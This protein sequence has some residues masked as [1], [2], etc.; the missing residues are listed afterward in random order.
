M[1]AGKN[2]NSVTVK[3]YSVGFLRKIKQ[4]IA[5]Y[6][7]RK[8]SQGVSCRQFLNWN[9]VKQVQILFYRANQA[10][11]DTM[12]KF[13]KFLLDEGKSVDVLIFVDAKK[14]DPSLQ[15][16]KGIKYYCRKQVNW[17]GKPA[18]DVY[19]DF[20]SQTSD[21]LIVVDFENRFHFQ[22]IATLSKAKTIV[23]PFHNDNLWATLLLKIKG[24]DVNEFLQQVI[25]YLGFINKK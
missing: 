17:F 24:N 2:L 25:H 8:A 10:Q 12:S 6:S 1:E 16:R 3:T 9:E 20:V 22:W 5:G 23:A 7:L 4:N 15:D 13:A 14:V 21:L 19:S 11:A 18:V